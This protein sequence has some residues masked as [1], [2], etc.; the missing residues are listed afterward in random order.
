MED[1]KVIHQL[2]KVRNSAEDD[3]DIIAVSY[4][5]SEVELYQSQNNLESTTEIKSSMEEKGWTNT[6]RYMNKFITSYN[7]VLRTKQEVERAQDIRR[8]LL[9]SL[10]DTKVHLEEI[11]EDT[12]P[13]LQSSYEEVIED[14]VERFTLLQNSELDFN[15]KLGMKF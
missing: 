9:G 14:I 2:I 4:D 8:K 7:G 15:I 11:K 5:L 12:K 13:E 6:I 3:Y 10:R 1:K